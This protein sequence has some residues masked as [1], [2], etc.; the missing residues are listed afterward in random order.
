MKPGYSY[1]TGQADS[2]LA[3]LLLRTAHHLLMEPSS[4]SAF[5]VASTDR[6]SPRTPTTTLSSD[7]NL[8][9]AY[10]SQHYCRHSPASVAYANILPP[11]QPKHAED[12]RW[13][14]VNHLYQLRSVDERHSSITKRLIDLRSNLG[15][16]STTSL[17]SMIGIITRGQPTI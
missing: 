3:A 11:N 14:T 9:V 13:R 15:C 7:V 1:L 4:K 6:P 2:R 8:R 5:W 10:F 17:Q 12:L 16:V